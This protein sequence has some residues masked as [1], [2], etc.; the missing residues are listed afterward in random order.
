[1]LPLE[2]KLEP[3]LWIPMNQFNIDSL[4][5]PYLGSS[6]YCKIC[7]KYIKHKDLEKHVEKHVKERE[8]LEKLKKKRAAERRRDT[9]RK[10]REAKNNKELEYD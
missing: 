4:I 6:G 3:F 9:L 10:A 1:L 8:K 5:G 2:E 7:D